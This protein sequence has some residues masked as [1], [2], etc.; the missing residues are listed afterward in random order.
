MD[1]MERDISN[2]GIVDTQAW[3]RDRGGKP[4]VKLVIKY[5]GKE[6]KTG[7]QLTVEHTEREPTVS[8]RLL[9]VED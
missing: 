1:S 5:N 9:Y 8:G 2:N 6:V 7:E 4:P 3:K